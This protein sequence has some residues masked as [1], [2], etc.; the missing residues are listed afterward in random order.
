MKR[1]VAKD[2]L[3]LGSETLKTLE[4]DWV[5][6][7]SDGMN[8][9]FMEIVGANPDF[10]AGVFRRVYIDD[11]YNIKV[12]THDGRTL[13]TDFELN[14]ASQRA[15]TLSFIWALM[16][17]SGTTAPRIIDTP[18]GMVAGGVKTRMVDVITKPAGSESPDFQV[19]LLLTRSEIRDVEEL[20]DQRPAS[21]RRCPARR[22]TRRTCVLPGR[23]TTLLSEFVAAGTGSPAGCV[24]DATTFSTASRSEMKRGRSD[25]RRCE[26]LCEPRP[27]H[28]QAVP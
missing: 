11:D 18:L 24:L 28:R 15:L 5:T 12:D 10:E 7:V 13:D 8:D 3:E 19:V 14:G 26:P 20:L 27:V 21:S 6:R 4:G 1:D 22:T 16:E 17:V 23:L 2:L 9:L 25:G